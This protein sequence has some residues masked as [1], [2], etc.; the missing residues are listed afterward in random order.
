[1]KR[2]RDNDAS[3]EGNIKLVY[4][5]I[6]KCFNYK[7]RTLKNLKLTKD[8]LYQQGKLGLIEASQS[9][10][11]SRGTKF[12]TYAC[13]LIRNHICNMLKSSFRH[14]LPPLLSDVPDR[15][16]IDKIELEIDFERCCKRCLDEDSAQIVYDHIFMGFTFEEIANK[17]SMPNRMQAF[18]AYTDSIEKIKKYIGKDLYL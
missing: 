13:G 14:N 9:Y 8:D 15:D 3:V 11:E 6:K 10:D 1:M 2:K 5:I 16:I 17:N 18:R 12:S 4:H 7:E